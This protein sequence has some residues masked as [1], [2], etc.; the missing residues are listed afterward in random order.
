MS[1]FSESGVEEAALVWLREVSYSI[2]D[3]ASAEFQGER[4]DYSQVVLEGRFRGALASLNPGIPFDALD[5]A[6][7]KLTRPDSPLLLV[8]NLVGLDGPFQH[9]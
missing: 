4:D 3:G 2:L 5:E 1:V 8:N 9:L 6:F 7:R